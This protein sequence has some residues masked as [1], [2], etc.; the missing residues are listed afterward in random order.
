MVLLPCCQACT[1]DT[2]QFVFSIVRLAILLRLASNFGVTTFLVQENVSDDMVGLSSQLL[3]NARAMQGAVQSR[4]GLL[5]QAETAQDVSL[6][7]ADHAVKTSTNIKNRRV[8]LVQPALSSN[9]YVLR[10]ALALLCG[11]CACRHLRRC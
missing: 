10:G 7:N 4:E 6:V 9:A 5:A 3:A 2:A 11:S 8:T 1:G